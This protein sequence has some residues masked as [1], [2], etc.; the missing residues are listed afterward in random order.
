MSAK[1]IPKETKYFTSKKDDHCI[2]SLSGGF[3]V[4]EWYSVPLLRWERYALLL[5]YYYSTNSIHM[6]SNHLLML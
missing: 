4:S 6:F 1:D 3:S 5:D 2:L